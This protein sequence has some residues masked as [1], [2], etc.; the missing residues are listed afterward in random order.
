M[1]FK[2]LNKSDIVLQPI[3]ENDFINNKSNA[4]KRS[5]QNRKHKISI[6]LNDSEL[7]LISKR[8][9]GNISVF[10][11]N[12]ILDSIKPNY[13]DV[14]V[15]ESNSLD[16]NKNLGFNSLDAGIESKLDSKIEIIDL[17]ID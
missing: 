1:G 4:K 10:C 16:T 12:A 9:N 2:D 8:A 6:Y 3:S 15:I 5:G 11:R 14:N 13:I 7:D 17:K